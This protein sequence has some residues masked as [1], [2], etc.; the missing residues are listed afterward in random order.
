MEPDVNLMPVGQDVGDQNDDNDV[1]PRTTPGSRYL[2][3]DTFGHK[4]VDLETGSF[5][6]ETDDLETNS[7]GN[8]ST[9]EWKKEAAKLNV[10]VS[11]E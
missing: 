2:E 1:K 4:V 10:R 9:V 3:T 8:Y 7:F 5:G 6:P 11:D